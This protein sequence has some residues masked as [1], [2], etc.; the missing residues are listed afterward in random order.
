MVS[1]CR[2]HQVSI[3]VFCM[4][5]SLKIIA[6]CGDIRAGLF[7]NFQTASK[8]LAML[9]IEIF[10][11]DLHRDEVLKQQSSSISFIKLLI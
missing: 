11:V 9:F 2:Q 5:E 7:N 8:L 3:P 10:M 4:T 1:H 6:H